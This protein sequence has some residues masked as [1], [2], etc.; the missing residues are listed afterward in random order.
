MYADE[1]HCIK[2]M[3]NDALPL[4]WLAQRPGTNGAG[5]DGRGRCRGSTEAR[6]RCSGPS[7]ALG[8]LGLESM[9]AA[10]RPKHTKEQ[11]RPIL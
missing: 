1:C 5:W 9:D 7:I 10:V 11:K 6:L 4:V 2:I 8:I 3:T